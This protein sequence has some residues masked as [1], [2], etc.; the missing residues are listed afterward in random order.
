M[1]L[2][3]LSLQGCSGGV[4]FQVDFWLAETLACEQTGARWRVSDLKLEKVKRTL[5]SIRPL[6]AIGD[7]MARNRDE[8]CPE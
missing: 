4:N 8:T 3:S 1:I 2:C 5:Q 6:A 7:P